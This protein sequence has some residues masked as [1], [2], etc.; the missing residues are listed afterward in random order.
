MK[1]VQTVNSLLLTA[2]FSLTIGLTLFIPFEKDIEPKQTNSAENDMKN[3]E[4]VED[5]EEKTPKRQPNEALLGELEL[6]NI[7]QSLDISYITIETEYLGVYFLTAYSDEET[8]SR[9]TAS[10]IE[11]HYSD[12]NFEPTTCA[13][14]PRMHRIGHEGDLFMIADKVYVAEDTG[15]AVIGA[16]IDCFVET[17]EE[18]RSFN[19]RYE[20]VYSVKFAENYL[21]GKERKIHHE[22]LS[23]YLHH[24]SAGHRCPYRDD[25]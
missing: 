8:N 3:A 23:N 15:S 17:M 18:V 11:V 2:S 5:T 1:L 20:T 4:S 19:T 7:W 21:S 13:V 6:R 22:W 9:A 16:H 25:S 24:R 10:G 14:D 12:S